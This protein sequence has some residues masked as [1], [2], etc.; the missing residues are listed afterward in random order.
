MQALN[1]LG[2]GEAWAFHTLKKSLTSPAVLT[3]PDWNNAFVAQT[4]AN[5]AGAGV[6]LL[7]PVGREERILAFASYRFLKTD[8]RRGPT[9]RECLAV[10][11]T[12]KH[13]RQYVASRCLT[14]VTDYS[15]LTWL[16]R[17][18]NLDPKLHRWALSLQEYDIDLRWRAGS[19]NHVPDCLSRLSHP[20][21]Q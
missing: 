14:L 13:F 1:R 15:A 3:F 2:G 5:S 21:Q 8:S 9:K 6:V 20:A 10:L 11:W 4:D 7:Q 18:R 16:F 19:V 12:I 17:S